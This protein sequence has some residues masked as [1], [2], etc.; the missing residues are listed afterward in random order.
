MVWNGVKPSHASIAE[1]RA[2]KRHAIPE[3]AYTGYVPGDTR[4]PEAP[5]PVVGKIKRAI[6]GYGGHRHNKQDMIGTTFTHGLQVVPH[7]V[8]LRKLK[9]PTKSK[10][11][12][13]MSTSAYGNFD[14]LSGY[15]Q[16]AEPP[17]SKDSNQD[18]NDDVMEPT[19]RSGYGEF[20][21]A[22]GYG[23]FAKP[24]KAASGYGE[25]EKASG[26][27]QFAAPPKANS[28]YGEFEKTSGYG[29]FAAP[30]A[31]AASGYGEFERASGYGQFAAPP[32]A[33]SGYGEFEKA[34]GYGQ[35]AAPPKAHS[36][37]GEFERASGYGQFAAPPEADSG[38]G[39]FERASGYG[40]FAEPPKAHSGY[41]EFE[42]ASGY[43]QFAAPPPSISSEYGEFA[44]ASGYGQFASPRHACDP[45]ND[46]QLSAPAIKR[47]VSRTNIQF[48]AKPNGAAVPPV[49]LGALHAPTK[50]S[51]PTA[52]NEIHFDVFCCDENLRA[53]Y[54]RAIQHVGGR[55][56]VRNLFARVTSVVHQK[57][58]STTEKRQRVKAVFQRVTSRD[59]T[60]GREQLKEALGQLSSLCTD[61]EI[62][63]MFSYFDRTCSGRV[64]A[65]HFVGL[66]DAAIG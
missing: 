35:Y 14:E 46:E 34:S 22:S 61:Q 16:F 31:K 1:R 24:P 23:Q 40:Q 17:R 60:V 18:D 29:Q 9:Q 65:S 54:M 50:P 57:K 53:L 4:E 7:P 56:S 37:Y 51:K 25:F 44:K 6:V 36:G 32:K 39:G 15:G 10:P 58:G 42:K 48:A 21:N 49:R 33:N 26:Y 11:D 38:Y 55:Q 41:G 5:K 43:G 62:L 47:R 13:A 45:S 2:M 19:K 30:P 52:S 59:G 20:V 64:R 28:G 27:G 63:A 12:K 66:F 3:H 8:E